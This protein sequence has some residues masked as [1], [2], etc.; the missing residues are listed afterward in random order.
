MAK[1]SAYYF[2]TKFHYSFITKEPKDAVCFHCHRYLM[3][4][5][6]N[7][8]ND[9]YMCLLFIKSIF[10]NWLVTN[11]KIYKNCDIFS[12]IRLVHYSFLNI[13]LYLKQLISDIDTV[14]LVCSKLIFLILPSNH[15]GKMS[16]SFIT[17]S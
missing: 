2:I 10:K 6:A 4:N 5:I 7:Y 13:G 16:F 14:I 9:C 3:I 1:E 8:Q 17:C 11:Y 15:K 12:L